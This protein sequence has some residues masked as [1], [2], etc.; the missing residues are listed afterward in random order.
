M[1]RGSVR[2]KI[3]DWDEWLR[4]YVEKKMMKRRANQ[5][6]DEEIEV[7]YFTIGI[8]PVEVMMENNA[9]HTLKYRVWGTCV[10]CQNRFET[11]WSNFVR[12]KNYRGKVVCGLCSRRDQYGEEWRKNNSAAQKR[13]QGTLEARKRMSKI[14]KES[15][16]N[17]PDRKERLSRSLKQA[18]KENPDL[19]KKISDASKRNWQSVEYQEKCTGHGYHHG[20]YNSRFGR[21]YFASSWELMYLVWCDQNESIQ[22][23]CRC[24]DR[25]RYRK[26]KGGYAYYHPD[27]SVVSTGGEYVVEIKG[28]RSP[29]LVERKRKA[30]VEHYR[31]TSKCYVILFRDDLKRLGCFLSNKK[32][33]QWIDTL[34]ASGKVH[35]HGFGK[36]R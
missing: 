34:A 25:I 11:L 8:I 28:G 12:R 18:Y 10:V 9:K 20:Y 2:Y 27:F 17:A 31:E 13:V 29:D 33:K 35:E 6:S 23:V 5:Y 7:P 26:P 24:E 30:A 22:L 32:V 4:P 36:K 15:W 19:R 16:A 1:P 14:L 21:L 3:D